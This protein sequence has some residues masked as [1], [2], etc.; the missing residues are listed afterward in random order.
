MSNVLFNIFPNERYMDLTIYQYGWEQCAPA[1]SYGPAARNHFLFHY[2]IKGKGILYNTNERGETHLYN[3]KRHQGFLISPQQVNTY[4]ADKE[5]PWEYTW[6]EFDGLRAKE[7]LDTAGLTSESPIYRSSSHDLRNQMKEEMLSIVHHENHSSLY[8]IGHLYL[9][10]DLLIQSSF[11]H[12]ELSTGR[13]KDFYIREAISFIEQNY[14]HSIT[15]EDIA[16]FCNLNRSYLGKLFRDELNQTPQQFL[17]YYRM[18][19]AAELLKFS[20]MT[21]G[22]VGKLVGYPNQLHFSRAFKNIFELPPSTW[23]KENKLYKPAEEI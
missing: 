21:V 17:I 23:R 13:L 22:E 4:I 3:L 12:R 16:I 10:L 1:H 9:F 15:V 11:N 8:Q 19:R 6:I 14:S 7:F 2:I 20:D 18:N 5:D